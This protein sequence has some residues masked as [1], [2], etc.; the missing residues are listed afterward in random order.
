MGSYRS[1]VAGIMLMVCLC[2]CHTAIG[3]SAWSEEVTVLTPADTVSPAAPTGLVA[4]DGNMQIDLDW[5]DNTEDD[6][7][8]YTVY[9]A[10]VSGGPYTAVAD[11]TESAYEDVGISVGCG[12]SPTYYYVVTATDLSGNP[13]S[14]AS[15]EDDAEAYCSMDPI[16]IDDNNTT[17]ITYTGTWGLQNWSGRYND[18]LHESSTAGATMEFTFIGDSIALHG[19]NSVYGG[20]GEI[21]IDDALQTTINFQGL[22]EPY[23]RELFSTSDLAN[24]QHTIRLQVLGNGWCYVDSLLYTKACAVSCCPD[25]A[26]EARAG[27]LAVTTSHEEI[28]LSWEVEDFSNCDEPDVI[29]IERRTTGDFELVATVDYTTWDYI[30]SCLVP[31]T[32]YTYRVLASNS[33]GESP[34]SAEVSATTEPAPPPLPPMNLMA[35]GNVDRVHLSWEYIPLPCCCTL[36]D[37]LYYMIYRSNVETGPFVPVAVTFGAEHIT[38]YNVYNGTYY[39]KLVAVDVT[40]SASYESEMDS[41]WVG[42]QAPLVLEAVTVDHQQIDL[43]WNDINEELG[44]RIL[45]DD[46]EIDMVNADITTYSDTGLMPDT[47]YAYRVIAF[48]AIGDTSSNT[49]SAITDPLPPP[50]A[51]SDLVALAVSGSQIDLTWTDNSGNED[52]FRVYRDNVEVGTSTIASYSDTGLSPLTTYCYKVT[53]YNAGSESA[54]SNEDCEDT[55]GGSII[56]DWIDD[57]DASI[58]YT[59]TWSVQTG[60]GGR[61]L[62]TIHESNDGGTPAAAELAFTGVE[63]SMLGDLQL[64]GGTIDVYIDDELVLEDVS[65]SGGP[66]IYQQEIF[67]ITGLSSGTHAVKIEKSGGD[68]IYVD[69]FVV[70]HY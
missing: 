69:T 38:D 64:W 70:G 31:N 10:M 3:A 27:L 19:E 60:W 49:E 22:Q 30:D 6:I 16:K 1:V 2:L 62:T 44:Y 59:G 41:A 33:Y 51:P 68:W 39:Y 61:Y 56:E 21:Y 66:D 15:N 52:G 47:T 12:G 40:G 5:A 57:A 25:R 63:I 36:P 7:D 4:T 34:Y 11:P 14:A 9:R 46:V 43:S 53:A 45:R 13:K 50:D 26:P 29:M 55:T 48:N 28:Q 37:V 58:T 18:T 32:Q 42:E 8:Y 20:D 23:D 24:E 67:K 65:Y 35:T 54:Q 17:S